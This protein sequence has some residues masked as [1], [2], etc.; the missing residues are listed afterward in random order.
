MSKAL[1]SV[2]NVQDEVWDIPYLI[3]RYGVSRST[4]MGAFF[5]Y[6]I[7]REKISGKY[8]FFKSDVLQWEITQ[9]CVPYG[10]KD[11]IVLPAFKEYSE[12]LIDEIKESRKKKNRDE[13][14]KLVE[15]GMNYGVDLYSEMIKKIELVALFILAIAL[16]L[17]AWR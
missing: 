16:M 10:K 9:K 5:A 14:R 3:G 1:D 17:W 6:G 11:C 8:A 12:R 7:P 2:L 13:I 4:I 15:E